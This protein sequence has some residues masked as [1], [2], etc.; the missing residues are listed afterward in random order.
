MAARPYLDA[1]LHLSPFNL[2]PRLPERDK[3]ADAA[4]AVPSGHRSRN[5]LL[6]LLVA[7]PHFVVRARTA[8]DVGLVL[9]ADHRGR[10]AAASLGDR[11]VRIRPVCTSNQTTAGKSDGDI[12][13]KVIII[14]PE[15]FLG[16]ENL[17]TWINIF[18]KLIHLLD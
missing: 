3:A 10:P 4:A 1:T 6:Q 12:V 11:T 17:E 18:Y 16:K 7:I 13:L 2:S 9:Q 5:L 15:H 14:I 8:D